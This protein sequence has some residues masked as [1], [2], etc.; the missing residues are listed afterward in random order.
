[1]NH[2]TNTIEVEY[3]N[4]LFEVNY[5]WRKGHPGDWLQPPDEDETDIQKV[6]ITA[7]IN[8]DGSLEDLDIDCLEYL[9]ASMESKII[10]GIEFDLETFK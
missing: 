10:E 3:H 6:T 4:F 1:M 5:N 8:D 7:Y 2:I 9:T